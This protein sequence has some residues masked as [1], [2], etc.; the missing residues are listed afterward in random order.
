M[1]DEPVDEVVATGTIRGSA[2][3]GGGAPSVGS[4]G[5]TLETP[6][7]KMKSLSPHKEI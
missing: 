2:W 6:N 3:T 5:P 4:N 1:S 7:L